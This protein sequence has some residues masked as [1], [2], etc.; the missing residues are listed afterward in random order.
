MTTSFKLAAQAVQ[1]NN[2]AD[3][4]K[5]LNASPELAEE[6]KLLNQ[7]ALLGHVEVA[8]LLLSCGSDPNAAVTSHEWYRP[9]HR[10]IEHRGHAKN[11]GHRAVV[12]SLLK[13][14]AS[15]T[16]R[17]TWMQ[18]V[19]LSVAGM[20]GD[21]EFIELLHQAG[22]EKNLFTAS[23]IADAS[24]VQRLLK[25]HSATKKDENNMTP[26]HYAALCGLVD[27]D[28]D[29]RKVVACLLDAGGNGDACED[30]GPYPGIPVL[31]FA[32]WKNYPAAEVLL[33]RGA[34]PNNGFG[35]CLWGKP[36]PMAELFLRHGADVNGRTPDGQPLLNSRIHWNLPDISLWLL[37]HGAD[38]NLTDKRGN[39]ALHEAAN[40]GIN[41]RVVEVLLA[42]GANPKLK[43]HST[44]TALDIA[45]EKNRIKLTPLL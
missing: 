32:A 26:L 34:N 21:R 38:P 6:P 31:H 25:R 44:Q 19:P 3:L 14:G 7:A 39:T 11:L 24:T 29:R 9:L 41:P 40:R 22:A 12:E 37:R 43:N 4:R 45:K 16:E 28:E 42:H 33:S 8:M 35:N 36:G 23:A 27:V 1:E 10:A 20:V 18:L 30:I 15:L 5:L 2:R 17:S 13:A